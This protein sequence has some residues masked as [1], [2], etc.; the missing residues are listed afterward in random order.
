MELNEA[1]RI[2][3]EF[4]KHDDWVNWDITRVN[5]LRTLITHAEQGSLYLSKIKKYEVR[6]E[7]VIL[8]AGWYV[9][10]DDI[11]QAFALPSIEEILA[12]LPEE[13]EQEMGK[14][15]SKEE[16][17]AANYMRRKCIAA[18]KGLWKEKGA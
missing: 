1:I 9:E 12:C 7:P 2:V 5:A 4:I 15:M 10:I 18:L 17:L 6:D 8:P 13:W 11:I 3:K 14:E 16:M